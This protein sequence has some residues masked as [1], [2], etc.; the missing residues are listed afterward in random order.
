M[1]YRIRLSL[2]S[3]F[4][5]MLAVLF[6]VAAFLY[7][8]C[9]N[10]EALLAEK[11]PTAQEMTSRKNEPNR[12]LKAQSLDIQAEIKAIESERLRL[13]QEVAELQEK[14]R[15]LQ[16]ENTLTMSELS[17]LAPE[18]YADFAL[19]L[20]KYHAG[21]REG[22]H[23]RCEWDM[24][25]ILENEG[26]LKMKPEEQKMC[27]AYLSSYQ[28][29]VDGILNDAWTEAEAEERFQQLEKMY[30][31]GYGRFLEETISHALCEALGVTTYEEA[32]NKQV[33]NMT[34]AIAFAMTPIWYYGRVLSKR[35]AR[36]I[37]EYD[38]PPLDYGMS[39][40]KVDAEI[41]ELEEHFSARGKLP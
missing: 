10:I 38:C 41:K 19:E 12:Q 24:L 13:E 6:G 35:Y 30:K 39:S 32:E 31:E 11:M 29:Y 1:N 23:V 2:I 9:R 33:D 4:L 20:K 7:F 22:R 25:R 5:T 34:T 28:E 8:D 40:D 27:E 21:M 26:L 17:M 36:E 15:M 18:V 37:L 14:C 16:Q 3:F